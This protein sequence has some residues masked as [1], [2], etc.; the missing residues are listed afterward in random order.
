MSLISWAFGSFVWHLSLCLYV[1]IHTY[2]FPI[3]F[4]SLFVKSKD[5]LKPDVLCSG[6]YSAWLHH[7]SL[8]DYILDSIVDFKVDWRRKAFISFSERHMLPF[9]FLFIHFTFFFIKYWNQSRLEQFLFFLMDITLILILYAILY[10]KIKWRT[11]GHAISLLNKR[12]SSLVL[13]TLFFEENKWDIY[14]VASN[15]P[16]IEVNIN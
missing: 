14:T 11:D 16:W 3:L 4:F 15:W 5:A 10:K 2:S 12:L 1:C 13:N 7:F 8:T 6:N 9:F